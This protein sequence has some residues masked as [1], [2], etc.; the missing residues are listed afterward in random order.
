V[1]IVNARG[2]DDQVAEAIVIHISCGDRP[3]KPPLVFH[4]ADL[5]SIRPIER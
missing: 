5:E 3:A 1:T 4:P 2:A